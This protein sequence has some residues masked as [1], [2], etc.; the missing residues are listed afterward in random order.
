MSSVNWQPVSTLHLEA[1]DSTGNSCLQLAVDF[2][3]DILK[4]T[5]VQFLANNILLPL[6]QVHQAAMVGLLDGPQEVV[7]DVI[8]V[9]LGGA[10]GDFLAVLLN[11]I[12]P[13]ILLLVFAIGSGLQRSGKAYRSTSRDVT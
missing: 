9:V 1:W 2:H 11:R 8:S 7:A 13:V 6:L 4:K 12:A 5:Q 3:I 10:N